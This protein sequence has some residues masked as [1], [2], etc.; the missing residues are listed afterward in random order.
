MMNFTQIVI[1]GGNDILT[2]FQLSDNRV[3]FTRFNNTEDVLVNGYLLSWKYFYNI[4]IHIRHE[5]SFVPS[6]LSDAKRIKHGVAKQF[7]VTLGKRNFYNNSNNW[8]VAFLEGNSDAVDMAVLS[9]CD[10]TIVSTGTFGW[11]A[12]WLAGGTT[13]I[14]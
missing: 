6:I 5:F 7:N 4:N 2:S 14:S 1:E 8:K 12:A 3:T 9:L 13:I 10:H 11:W